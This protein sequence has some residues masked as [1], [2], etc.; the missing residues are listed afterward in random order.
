MDKYDWLMVEDLILDHI[1]DW[2]D[3]GN[4][5]EVDELLRLL[6]AVRDEYARSVA[7]NG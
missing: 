1:R 5:D 3:I 2:E 4:T 6:S 7:A